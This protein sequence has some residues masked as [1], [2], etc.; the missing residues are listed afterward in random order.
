MDNSV[1]GKTMEN[2]RKRCNMTVVDN[3]D[4]V[5]KQIAK[6]SFINLVKIND[7]FMKIRKMKNLVKLDKPFY[8]GVAVLDYSTFLMYNYHYGILKNLYGNKVKLIMTDT[9]SLF[10]EIKTDDVYKDLFGK[11]SKCK[12]YFDTWN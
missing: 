2:V 9:D 4:N 3:E 7:N 8:V 6:P 1:Y 11:N 12:D 10:Y 5:L